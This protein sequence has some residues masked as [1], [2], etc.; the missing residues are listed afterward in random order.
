MLYLSFD[1]FACCIRLKS[2]IISKYID[3]IY[4]GAFQ[5][6]ISL[7]KVVCKAPNVRIREDTFR[8]CE[9]LKSIP[10]NMEVY[11]ESEE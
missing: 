3:S 8:G 2:V 5:E 7:E 10:E 11:N 6:C 9:R 4:S 1:V